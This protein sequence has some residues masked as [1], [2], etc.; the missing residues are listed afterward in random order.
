ML[1]VIADPKKID[2]ELSRENWCNF[3]ALFGLAAMSLSAIGS[4]L[5]IYCLFALLSFSV[6]FY[7]HRLV[8]AGYSP[9]GGP[10]NWITFLRLLLLSFIFLNAYSLPLFW[11][12]V[13]AV[14]AVLMDVIDGIVARRMGHD[15]KFGQYFDM[16]VD[17]FYVMGMGLYFYHTTNLGLW[18][19][20]PGFLRNVYRLLVW[21]GPLKGFTED[22]KKY[23]ATLA[24]VNFTLILVAII[25][26]TAVQTSILIAS[27]CIVSG[28]FFLSFVEYF[29]HAKKA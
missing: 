3:N 10:A 18:L 22:K 26:P 16:E 20:I 29:N 7:L 11:F 27:T 23:A 1:K 9:F 14:T 8:L 6:F 24:G 17:A 5:T 13:C 12:F 28:S 19:L 25:M 2:L 15:S 21:L 4:D